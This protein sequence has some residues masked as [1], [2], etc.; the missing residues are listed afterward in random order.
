MQTFKIY[1]HY[2]KFKYVKW[3]TNESS[4][5]L[6]E[7]WVRFNS[8]GAHLSIL[9][10]SQRLE[11]QANIYTTSDYPILPPLPGYSPSSHDEMN[12]H[13]SSLINLRDICGDF[14][15]HCG[16]PPRAVPGKAQPRASWCSDGMVTGEIG[17]VWWGAQQKR[18]W[19][20]E[21]RLQLPCLDFQLHPPHRLRGKGKITSEP[22][23]L[24]PLLKPKEQKHVLWSPL[25][26]LRVNHS[27][28]KG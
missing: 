3:L 15:H 9:H 24:L 22:L 4:V 20:S 8:L 18:R 21:L 16:A 23:C 13:V 1:M 26:D 14:T 19:G 5:C 10:L 28:F 17:E 27:A 2:V 11:P 6:W 7:M 12:S 25:Q